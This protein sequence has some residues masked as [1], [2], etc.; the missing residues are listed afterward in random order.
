MGAHLT[1]IVDGVACGAECPLA[2]ART[3]R[4]KDDD[5]AASQHFRK[6]R[7]AA[8]VRGRTMSPRDFWRYV[9]GLIRGS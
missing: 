1:C 5:R 6:E 7:V 9:G 3:H 8:V 4:M 2:G